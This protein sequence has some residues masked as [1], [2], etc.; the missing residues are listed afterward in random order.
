MLKATQDDIWK[1]RGSMDIL[2]MVLV[3][4]CDGLEMDG[5]DEEKKKLTDKVKKN[6]YGTQFSLK[7][8][9]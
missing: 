5:T 9:H 6:I 8:C 4:V 2:E 7:S 1:C 3:I